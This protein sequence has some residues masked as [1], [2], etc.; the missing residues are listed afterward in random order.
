MSDIFLIRFGAT[1]FPISHRTAAYT[2]RVLLAL[3]WIMAAICSIPQALV[4]SLHTHPIIQ[5][6]KQCMN[7]ITLTNKT[8][9]LAYFLYFLFLSWI[10]PI[11]VMFFCYVSILIKIGGR[12]LARQESQSS[13]QNLMGHVGKAKMKT[14]KM[15]GILILGFILTWLPYQINCLWYYFDIDT[16]RSLDRRVQKLLWNFASMANVINPFLYAMF[17]YGPSIFSCTPSV[18]N[19]R[20][21]EEK[22][23]EQANEHFPITGVTNKL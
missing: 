14:L 8:M 6:Y 3:A 11:I 18:Q 4:F 10:L 7:T 17:D 1:V 9:E 16:F 15:T 22:K 13:H 5:S 21:N 19:D 23:R 20:E 2:T 12:K